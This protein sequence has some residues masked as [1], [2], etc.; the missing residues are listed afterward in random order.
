MKKKMIIRSEN[1]PFTKE[2]LKHV[3]RPSVA[4]YLKTYRYF[5]KRNLAMRVN[6]PH[7]KIQEIID[8]LRTLVNTGWLKASDMEATKR[9]IIIDILQNDENIIPLARCG[10]K[11]QFS[12]EGRREDF[13]INFLIYALI[14]DLKC[15]T[16]KYN[17]ALV[18]G[19]LQEHNIENSNYA[20]LGKKFRRLS[21]SHIANL[22]Q[23]FGFINST[24][25]Q[26]AKSTMSNNMPYFTL[27]ILLYLEGILDEKSVAPGKINQSILNLSTDK[28]AKIEA[29]FHLKK[30]HNYPAN[31]FN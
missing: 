15:Y 23:A 10:F 17:Y 8:S 11:K 28:K 25:E 29:L 2:L 27:A 4:T 20:S 14:Y 12:K 7:K 1:L 16:G 22:W 19:F 6:F 30:S 18:D 26:F 13:A 24:A 31:K 3:P 5:L 21:F 9:K